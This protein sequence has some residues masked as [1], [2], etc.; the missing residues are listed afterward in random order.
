MEKFWITEGYIVQ[1]DLQDG[2]SIKQLVLQSYYRDVAF[3]G[4]Y[5]DVG[6]QGRD[7]TLW[8]AKQ[9]FLDWDGYWYQI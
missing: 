8:L 3:K 1:K 6:H 9:I 7:K 5:N 2:V 4:L